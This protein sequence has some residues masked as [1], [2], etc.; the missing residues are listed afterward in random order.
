MVISTACPDQRVSAAFTLPILLLLSVVEHVD[1]IYYMTELC[2][3][4]LTPT[5]DRILSQR[6][7]V[8]ERNLDCVLVLKA[9]KKT[10]SV[11]IDYDWYDMQKV[12]NVCID[13]FAI[14]D[15]DSLD[16]ADLLDWICG[17]D[18]NPMTPTVF[19]TG[20]TL[21]LRLFTTTWVSGRGFSLIFASV[22][23]HNICDDGKYHCH[24]DR[25]IDQSAACD[26]ENNCGDNS[27]ELYCQIKTKSIKTDPIMLFMV[28]TVG[29]IVL[30]AVALY[31]LIHLVDRFRHYGRCSSSSRTSTPDVSIT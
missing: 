27:D 19:S 12:G 25:C 18:D 20:N 5:H 7:E 16:P 4:T 11:A 22:E 8:Y 21:T 23:Y 2:N 15:G 26:G 31:G 29:G 6:G 9:R 17:R 1:S 28:F 14:H 24:N 30:L 3:Q 10:M 13:Y